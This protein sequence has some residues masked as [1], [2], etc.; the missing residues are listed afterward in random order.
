MTDSTHPAKAD[1]LALGTSSAD[2]LPATESATGTTPYGKRRGGAAERYF[3][4]ITV[5]RS[6]L[7]SPA[8]PDGAFSV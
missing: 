1:S 8:L 2:Y 4:Q 6:S 5:S 3:D 7:L